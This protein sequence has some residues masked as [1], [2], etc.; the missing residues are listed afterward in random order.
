MA[1]RRLRVGLLFGGRSCEH[2]VSVTSAK[3]VLSAMDTR[4]YD[5][6]PVW[7][8]RSGTWKAME[9]AQVLALEGA[10]PDVATPVSMLPDPL[11][12]GLV[13]LGEPWEEG[14]RTQALDVVFPLIHGPMG[15]DGTLQ[16]LLE[17]AGNAYVG[18]GVLGSALSMDKGVAKALLEHHGLRVTPYRVVEREAWCRSAASITRS[19][20]HA[21]PYPWFVKPANMGSS[22][23]VSK[24]R[25]IGEFAE[26]M[27]LAARFDHKI[28]VEQGV[29]QAREIEVAVLGNREP[30]ASVPGEILPAAEFYDYDAKYHNAL[31]RLSIPADLPAPV[32]ERVRVQALRAF[33]VLECAGLA[34]VDFLLRGTD[35]RIFV[36]EVNTLPGFTRGSMFPR[37]WEACGVAPAA[38][39][40]RLITLALQ[41]HGERASLCTEYHRAAA[42]DSATHAA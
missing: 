13:A 30:E 31:T 36:S 39:L 9:P 19:C 14:L 2:A 38:L 29:E 26:A 8:S 6:V 5:V 37:L 41:R 7:V 3:C 28:V 11:H 12:T 24:V 34:R 15:E 25:Q 22:V 10:D 21:F 23:G 18:S 20:E 33:K 35:N 27:A 32:A 4:K 16:G 40:D 1:G 42:P 17:L